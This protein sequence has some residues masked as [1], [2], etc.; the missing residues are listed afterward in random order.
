LVP[1]G[2]EAAAEARAAEPLLRV[3][4]RVAAPGEK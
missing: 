3:F 2:C 4:C 1:A